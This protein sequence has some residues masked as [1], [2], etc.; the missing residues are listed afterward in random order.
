M[1]LQPVKVI[2]QAKDEAS[3]VVDGIAGY[4]KTIGATLAA[5][6][7]GDFVASSVKS[8]GELQDS[9]GLMNQSLINVG[10]DAGTVGTK[11]QK[12]FEDNAK[13]LGFT[14]GEQA[15]AYANL[16]R[17]IHDPQQAQEALTQA[18][19]V[20]A[21]KHIS[22]ADAAALVARAH[23]G[24]AK[25]IKIV[26]NAE[27]AAAVSAESLTGKL[28][29]MATEYEN[30]KNHLGG[31][32]AQSEG[33][34]NAAT[35]IEGAV[36]S[37]TQFV[38]DHAAEIS[39][40]TGRVGEMVVMLTNAMPTLF[41][42]FNLIS[43]AVIGTSLDLEIASKQLTWFFLTMDR[44]HAKAMGLF[45]FGQTSNN[46]KMFAQELKENTD[47][48]GK[49]IDALQEKFKHLDDTGATP[50]PFKVDAP[51][52]KKTGGGLTV[53]DGTKKK[54]EEYWKKWQEEN[55]KAFNKS[56]QER[57][58]FL[59]RMGMG[60]AGKESGKVDDFQGDVLAV[61]AP[62][63]TKG[64]KWTMELND[65][66]KYTKGLKDHNAE[67]AKAQKAVSQYGQAWLAAFQAM[68]AGKNAF[69]EIEKAA[70]QTIAN[71]AGKK[72]QSEA[73]EGVA[74]L[75]AGTWP[76]NPAA[77]AAAGK[78][79]AAAALFEVLA[80]AVG[81]VGSGGGGGGGGNGAQANSTQQMG[82]SSMSTGTII[83]KGDQY[84]DMN[85]PAV[86]DALANALANVK[87]KN[88]IS[89]QFQP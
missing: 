53:D 35:A 64:D 20:S 86:R 62:D 70:V 79:F 39:A 14:V 89:L 30:L 8:F 57:Y 73:A 37:L 2:I 24:Q 82:A 69:K 76:P 74:S 43:K 54:L 47:A 11:M 12:V 33:F 71:I 88:V 27:G 52:G 75:A 55:E 9:I 21:A 19:D 26:Q 3:K 45:T 34:K 42:F 41:S 77:I 59:N 72:A 38:D 58:D 44:L 56:E 80:G 49:D 36:V 87:D 40:F 5:Y 6:A 68:G 25:A 78:H 66:T 67:L 23:E 10:A 32:I 29:I 1:A 65:L 31:V 16:V 61:P 46:W 28:H 17:H 83:I 22:L 48:M 84:L 4:V 60:G 7:I 18:M 81:S 50:N 51:A 85:N 13:K 63:I 15:D